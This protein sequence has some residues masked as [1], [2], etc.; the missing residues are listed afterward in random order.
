MNL[1]IN[2]LI[3]IS[4]THFSLETDNHVNYFSILL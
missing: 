2:V 1:T 4:N 3:F